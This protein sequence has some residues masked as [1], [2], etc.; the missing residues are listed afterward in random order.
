[1]DRGWG[2]RSGDVGGGVAALPDGTV[3]LVG[4]SNSFGGRGDDRSSSA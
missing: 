3:V 4:D 2:G 1:M